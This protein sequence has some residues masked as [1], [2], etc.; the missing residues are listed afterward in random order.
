MNTYFL[1]II[2]LRRKFGLGWAAAELLCSLVEQKQLSPED[3]YQG[4]YEVWPHETHVS[5]IDPSFTGH[6]GRR[7]RR[8]K[9]RN[10]ICASGR[11]VS[12]LKPDRGVQPT[13]SRILLPSSS[14]PGQF[15]VISWL[16]LADAE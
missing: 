7:R 6:P 1:K 2:Q 5:V 11:S 16:F 4:N 14:D 9:P 15:I 12:T 13:S 10:D 8:A 3:V